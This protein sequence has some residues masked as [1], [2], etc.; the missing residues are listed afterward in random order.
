MENVERG[1]RGEREKESKFNFCLTQQ[2]DFIFIFS[3]TT[4][5]LFSPMLNVIRFALIF[6]EI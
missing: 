1:R 4:T 3:S 5:M 6:D 2:V